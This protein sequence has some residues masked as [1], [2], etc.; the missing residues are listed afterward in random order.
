M[1][2]VALLRDGIVVADQWIDERSA[3]AEKLFGLADTV[4]RGANLAPRDLDAFAVSIGPGSFT[5]LRIGLSAVKGFHLALGK[6]VVAV[7]TLMAL[8][9]RCM[10]LLA[11]DGGHILAVLDARRDEAYCQT[12][13]V[14]DGILTPA[15]DVDA[16]TVAEIVRTLPV[17]TVV[18][19]GD[20][21][22]KIAAGLPDGHAVVL[23]D[24]AMA[25]C[26]AAAV[27]QIAAAMF[28]RG[29]VAD[30]GTLEPDVCERGLPAFFSL[31]R[32]TLHVLVPTLQGKHR[33][34]NPEEGDP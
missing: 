21:R 3:H 28:V 34:R 16:R 5:G 25:R 19:T 12:F 10:P 33:C 29:E 14:A 20:A 15:G 26:S 17:G 13:R 9:Y 30:A 32:G 4:L 2:G 22:Q 6:P 31:T 7:P 11:E 24:D 23:A 27:A 1:C 8:A 18:V